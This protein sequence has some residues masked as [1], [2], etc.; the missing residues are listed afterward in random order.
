MN[1]LRSVILAIF[2]AVMLFLG[3]SLLW[4]FVAERGGF[5][6]PFDFV[7]TARFIS[8]GPWNWRLGVLFLIIGVIIILLKMREV[9]REQCIAFD[10][11]EGEVAISM[12]AVEEFIRRVG[13]EFD[14][15]K[16]LIPS[17]H[18]GPEG[19]GVAIRMD[20]WSGSNIPR[21]SEDMQN[22]I[23]SRVQDT[24]GINVNYVSVSVG[25]II[26]GGEEGGDYKGE[27]TLE[28]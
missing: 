14:G 9:R 10:N 16:S 22:T 21:L 4:S 1:W 25:K 7:A 17:I 23:K 27:E 3:I 11:P 18:A 8:A 19:I 28:E 20:L 2:T 12:D 6:N 15:V 26:S 5:G 24:L 13:R